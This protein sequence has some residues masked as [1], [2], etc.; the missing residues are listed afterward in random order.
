MGQPPRHRAR[1]QKAE[2]VFSGGTEFIQHGAYQYKKS[3]ILNRVHT[4]ME[5]YVATKKNRVALHVHRHRK[6]ASI[7]YYGE[8][9]GCEAVC[10]L[11]SYL[12]KVTQVNLLL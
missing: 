5:Y 9:T 12:Y 3:Y 7:C 2:G 4:C 1:W 8:K 10:A 6:H 11:G